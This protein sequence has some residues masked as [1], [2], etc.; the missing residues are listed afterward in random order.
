MPYLEAPGLTVD[1]ERAGSGKTV[2]VLV[3][4]NYGSWRWWKP[5]LDRVPTGITI[6]APT[7]RG[8][9]G[10]RGAGPARTVHDLAQ[11]LREFARGLGL[12]RF[13][14][15]GH[16]LGGAVALQY[17]LSWPET[18]RGLSLVAPAPGDGLAAMGARNDM[19]GQVIRWTD[20]SLLSSRIALTTGMRFA[21]MTGMYRSTIARSL[22]EM[23]PSAN[24][25]D[26]DFDT[27]LADALAVDDQ[28]L[29]DVYEALKRWDVAAVLPRLSVQVRI[30]AG[31]RDG[32]VALDSLEALTRALPRAQLDV[33]D[34][35]GH[36][37][38]L[39]R[40]GEF[41]AWLAVVRERRFSR[42]RRLVR[43]II[44]KLRR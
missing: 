13:H 31:R 42:I 28:V 9:G 20:P 23:M 40:P 14:L 37:P 39:E 36:S 8:F 12:Q 11:D 1:Y 44:A 19:L 25:V 10:T 30:L 3:H 22:A 32:L 29:L 5:I 33:W 17:A 26:V 15:V 4:G 16:S 18:L 24:P 21:R 6:Y 34:D 27:L 2:A 35:V 7:L 41:A 43:W 38:Q